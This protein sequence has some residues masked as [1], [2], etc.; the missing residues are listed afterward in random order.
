MEIVINRSQKFIKKGIIGGEQTLQLNLEI[1]AILSDDEFEL[2]DKYYEP[3]AVIYNYLCGDDDD[4]D[5]EENIQ[6]RRELI[7]ESK[8][9]FFL[10]EFRIFAVT[11]NG[12]KDIYLLQEIIDAAEKGLKKEIGKL[13]KLNSWQGEQI[14]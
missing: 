3:E 8:S 9:S 13:R 14:K 5:K 2:M 11:R 4:D 10:S 1:S 12:Y 6:K 7:D